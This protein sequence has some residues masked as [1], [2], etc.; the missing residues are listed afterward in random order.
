M[1]ARRARGE[2]NAPAPIATAEEGEANRLRQV[3]QELMRYV[4]AMPTGRGRSGRCG[5]HDAREAPAPVS[6]HRA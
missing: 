6:R 4:P 2:S 5:K 1:P 3:Q